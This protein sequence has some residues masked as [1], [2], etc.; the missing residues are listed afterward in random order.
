VR[1]PVARAYDPR[2]GASRDLVCTHSDCSGI[3][4]LRITG[5]DLTSVNAPARR[6]IENE[7]VVQGNTALPQCQAEA[8]LARIPVLPYT[9]DITGN[10][11][12]GRC[13]P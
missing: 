8:I 13:P 5:T 11:T 9:L 3:L 2:M 1:S 7:I 12:N 6:R 10:D 4:D